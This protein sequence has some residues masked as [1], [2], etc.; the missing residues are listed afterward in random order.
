MWEKKAKELEQQFQGEYENAT[1]PQ[2]LLMAGKVLDH[3]FQ[4]CADV[5]TR[6]FMIPWD[7][8]KQ[9]R[10]YTVKGMLDK[11]M[12]NE[13]IIAPLTTP[14][15]VKH[16]SSITDIVSAHQVKEVTETKQ[17]VSEILNGLA[18]L[19]VEGSP[20]A[21][22][23]N[24]R[25][26]R[27]RGIEEPETQA[28]V[29]GPRDGFIE[30][31]ETNIALVRKRLKTPK[32]KSVLV[33]VGALTQTNVSVMHLD[34]IA[35]PKVLAEV[36]ARLDKIDIDG[37][38]DSGQLEQ[39]IE[40]NSISIFP[41]IANTERP[42]GVAAALLDGRIAILVDNS[43]FALVV[44]TV[45]TDMLQASE[46][47]YERFQFATA[48]RL[49]RYIMFVLALLGPS[50]YIAITTFHH[51]MIPTTLLVSL[52][53]TRAGIPFPAIVEAMLMELA[54]EALREAGVRLPK[55]VGQAVSIVG[56]LVIGQAAVQAGIVSPI[57]VIVVA[58]TGIASFTIPGFNVAISIRLL[59]FPFMV[60]AATLGLY[61]VNLGLSILLIHLVSLR[62]FGVPYL[63]P[64]APMTVFDWKDVILR[65]PTWWMYQRPTFIAQGNVHR[66]QSGARSFQPPVE[67]K[68]E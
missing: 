24:T 5:G 51:E 22:S 53:A 4:D 50:L 14:G 9:A 34:G 11:D 30:D 46:D 43:P 36:H 63:S 29:R 58:S 20:V 10:I 61:G 66:Q 33:A 39:L 12:L 48:I 56:A 42:D 17:A 35:D 60:L 41:Q 62:S 16:S 19:I 8:P 40:D 67:D 47:Y 54:F 15:K 3:I 65:A 26:A 25:A 52:I 64:I 6:D 55:P 13:S 21:W 18:L 68:D 57:M 32:L 31:I 23:I 44:P 59:R 45:L 38:V 1:L 7:S 28:V 27:V 2:D 49:L 37:V